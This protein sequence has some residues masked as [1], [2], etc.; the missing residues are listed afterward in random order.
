VDIDEEEDVDEVVEQL[1][2]DEVVEQVDVDEVVEQ[3]TVSGR[4]CRT[5]QKLN[6]RHLVQVLN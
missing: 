3:I 4:A 6:R 5:S 1:D 2:I